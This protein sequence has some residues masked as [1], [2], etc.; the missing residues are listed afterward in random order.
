MGKKLLIL[1]IALTL[2]FVFI[3]FISYVGQNKKD[4]VYI[5]N[6]SAFVIEKNTFTVDITV[7][8]GTEQPSKPFKVKL[9][10]NNPLISA[11][12]GFYEYDLVESDRSKSP[13]SIEPHKEMVIRKSFPL[14]SLIN[15]SLVGDEVDNSSNTPSVEVEVITETY[16]KGFTLDKF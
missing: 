1:L 7:T 9:K 2:V 3:V 12:L 8:N 5:Q 15:D 11:A 16:T 6:G 13:F 14:K 4:N 10:I